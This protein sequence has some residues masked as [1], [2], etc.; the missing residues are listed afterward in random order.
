[1]AV[2][3]ECRFYQLTTAILCAI[4]HFIGGSSKPQ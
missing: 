4:L 2:E 1:V 3:T